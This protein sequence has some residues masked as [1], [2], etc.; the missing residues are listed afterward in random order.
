MASPPGKPWI[1]WGWKISL[2][3]MTAKIRPI[4]MLKQYIN[5][6]TEVDVDSGISILEVMK[7]LGIPSEVVALVLVN[8]NHQNKDFILKDGDKVQLLAVI[9]GG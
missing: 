2:C 9:G 3:E 7:N 6:R 5:D 4:G 1:S 8:E